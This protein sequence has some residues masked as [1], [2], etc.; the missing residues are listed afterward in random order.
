[1]IKERLQNLTKQE[2]LNVRLH[3]IAG[4]LT[5]TRVINIHSHDHIEVIAILSG[6][7]E[8]FNVHLEKAVDIKE[9]IESIYGNKLEYGKCFEFFCDNVHFL[10]LRFGEF[11]NRGCIEAKTV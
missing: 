11:N 6:T 8:R 2:L 1:M 10:N 3:T 9:S 5:S 4:T 7:P